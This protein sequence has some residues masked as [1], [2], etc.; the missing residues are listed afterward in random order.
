MQ[1]QNRTEF[2]E[3]QNPK[4]SQDNDD[5]KDGPQGLPN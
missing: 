2:D 5:D 1:W 4:G 3:F